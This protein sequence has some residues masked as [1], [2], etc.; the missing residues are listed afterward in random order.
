MP[1]SQNRIGATQDLQIVNDHWLWKSYRCRAIYFFLYVL[2]MFHNTNM[3]LVGAKQVAQTDMRN[4]RFK[5]L[6]DDRLIIGQNQCSE[7]SAEKM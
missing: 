1:K 3:N 5:A 2:L 4:K 7:T 6:G